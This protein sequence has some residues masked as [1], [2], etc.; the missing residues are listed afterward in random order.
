MIKTV[1]LLPKIAKRNLK[2]L[3]LHILENNCTVFIKFVGAI[4]PKS[5]KTILDC[6]L[7]SLLSRKLFKNPTKVWGL[8]KLTKL[9][10]RF[11]IEKNQNLFYSFT[12][13]FP[14]YLVHD[15]TK[16]F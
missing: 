6:Q 3:F 10:P 2:N 11:L 15:F 14:D 8:K 7:N 12:Y 1:E 16:E 4:L 9:Y 13:I 5:R